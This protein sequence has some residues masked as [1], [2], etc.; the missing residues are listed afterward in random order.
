MDF[1]QIWISICADNFGQQTLEKFIKQFWDF[2][3]ASEK[4]QKNAECDMSEILDTVNVYF[5]FGI[6]RCKEFF[7][8][9]CSIFCSTC[10]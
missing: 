3:F 2:S 5:H 9:F 4:I 1:G 8:W 10:A 6:I 7:R